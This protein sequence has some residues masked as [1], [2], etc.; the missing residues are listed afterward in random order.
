ME[1]L[2]SSI[3][4]YNDECEDSEDEVEVPDYVWCCRDRRLA[5]TDVHDLLAERLEEKTY[6]GAWDGVPE[7][8]IAEL[9]SALDKFYTASDGI[10]GYLPDYTKVLVLT[11]KNL[12][13]ETCGK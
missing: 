8:A 10:V 13:V 6:E 3:A 5:H 7:A 1:D 2:L 4:A 9:Q 11:G 12:E